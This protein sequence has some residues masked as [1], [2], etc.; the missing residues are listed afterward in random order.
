MDKKLRG[1]INQEA[2]T[3]E[4]ESSTDMDRL[5]AVADWT[6]A[7]QSL[8][9]HVLNESEAFRSEDSASQARTESFFPSRGAMGGKRGKPIRPPGAGGLR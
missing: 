8:A 1:K 7:V 3:V 4:I 6:A 9:A 5:H 2:G